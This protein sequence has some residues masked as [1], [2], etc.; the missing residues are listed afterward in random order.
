MQS[1]LLQ[2]STRLWF[3]WEWTKLIQLL[4]KSL[5]NFLSLFNFFLIFTN[6]HLN[7]I[8]FSFL[9]YLLNFVFFSWF[10]WCILGI[11]STDTCS[12]CYSI[13]YYL[14]TN[15]YITHNFRLHLIIT[16][17]WLAFLIIS[18]LFKIVI[19]KFVSKPISI[20]FNPSVSS[21]TTFNLT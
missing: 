15:N 11:T 7:V 13:L 21:I 10:I 8:L 4:F 18:L 3:Y 12:C 19:D 16:L 5:N 17:R 14:V 2:C 6:Q 9:S 1:P 20:A